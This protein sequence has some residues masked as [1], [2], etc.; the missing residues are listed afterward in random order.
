MINPTTSRQSSLQRHM[1]RELTE[2][3]VDEGRFVITGGTA[4]HMFH[5]MPWPNDQVEL[6]APSSE[7]PMVRRTLD[8]VL[9]SL[10][11]SNFRITYS[12]P[13]HCL[14]WRSF[15]SSFV[16]IFPLSSSSERVPTSVKLF[17]DYRRAETTSLIR[18]Q[19]THT[20]LST[21]AWLV[22]FFL[23]T[24]NRQL[25]PSRWQ[26]L[27]WLLLILERYGLSEVELPGIASQWRERIRCKVRLVDLSGLRKASAVQLPLDCFFILKKM[28]VDGFEQLLKTNQ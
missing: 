3:L 4:L 19:G 15:L 26:E 16:E 14:G 5:G 17:I 8:A 2:A 23:H 24:R 9:T 1:Q 11:A 27:L 13:L 10:N 25:Q 7:L 20:L 18:A 12:P 21:A 6:I 22:E 28:H